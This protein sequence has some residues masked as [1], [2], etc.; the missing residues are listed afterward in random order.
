MILVTAAGGHQGV[1]LIPRLAQAGAEVRGL[2]ASE[3]GREELLALG[4]ADVLIGDMRDA[5]VLC[6]AMQDVDAVYHICPG[7]AHLWERDMGYAVIDAAI[8]AGVRHLVYSSVLHPIITDLLQHATKRDVEERLVSSPVN[9]TILQPA[10]YMQFLV[11][12]STYETGELVMAW[13]IDT[14]Q[15]A[16]D[17]DDLA[18]V[19]A[20]VLLEGEPHYGAT[21]ELAGPGCFD[22]HELAR[23]IARVSGREVTLRRISVEE[24]VQAT[25]EDNLRTVN[26]DADR[27]PGIAFQMRM[28]RALGTWYERHDFV[29]NANVLTMLL[30]RTPT[31][32]E[33]FVAKDH[34]RVAGTAA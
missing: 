1:R 8:A 24:F 20:K 5:S 22:G 13:S 28:L 18:I 21:Y 16:I 10:D 2:R 19:A 33:Q 15:S 27:E 14:R 32:L 34:A 3:S 23:T 31:T 30:G 26:A 7:G 25:A 11:P 4:A 9:F 12:P 6:A 29:G 17:L